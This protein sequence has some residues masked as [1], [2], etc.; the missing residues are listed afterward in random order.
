M[1]ATE[2]DIGGSEKNAWHNSILIT[3][4]E[5]EPNWQE[6]C[7]KHHGDEDIFWL[8]ECDHQSVKK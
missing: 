1:L 4:E 3:Q 6:N 5:N 8:D 7:I 2:A